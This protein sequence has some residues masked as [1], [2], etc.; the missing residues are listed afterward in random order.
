[1]AF[2][3]LTSYQGDAGVR[4]QQTTKTAALGG[5]TALHLGHHHRRLDDDAHHAGRSSFVR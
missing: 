4:Q 2:A 1:M 3:P 5:L